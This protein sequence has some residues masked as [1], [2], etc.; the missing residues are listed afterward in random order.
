MSM[1]IRI[2]INTGSSKLKVLFFRENVCFRVK[3]TVFTNSETKI[4]KKIQ[5]F[6]ERLIY[7]LESSIQNLRAIYPQ[8]T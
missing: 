7:G 5:T 2:S 8:I 1:E 4:R 6:T 3:N